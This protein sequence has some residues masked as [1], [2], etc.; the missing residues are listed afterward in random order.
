MK[1]AFLFMSI[2]FGA[3]LLKA[4][5]V[6]LDGV[7]WTWR[8]EGSKAQITRAY[9]E[10]TEVTIPESFTKDSV[11]YPVANIINLT[12]DGNTSIRTLTIPEGVKTLEV[13]ALWGC[14]ALTTLKLPTTIHYIGHSAFVECPN[15]TTIS[16]AKD[17]PH[18]KMD[19]QMTCV[20]SKDGFTLYT[21]LER[22]AKDDKFVIP[23]GVKTIES[24]AFSNNKTFKTVTIPNTV[25]EIKSGAFSQTALE[26]LELPGSVTTIGTSICDNC[27]NLKTVT[28]SD[29]IKRI[30]ANAFYG[31]RALESI[32]L[33][34]SVESV[35]QYAFADSRNLVVTFEGKPPAVHNYYS[36][37]MRSYNKDRT[38]GYYP[39]AYAKEWEAFFQANYSG[40]KEFYGLPMTEYD[41]EIP[42]RYFVYTQAVGDGV[43]GGAGWYTVGETVT[44]T[45]FP[46]TESTFCSYL[47]HPDV[48]IG[49][50]EHFTH[51]FAMPEHGVNV[52]AYFASKAAIETHCKAYQLTTKE[53]EKEALLKSGEYFTPDS[54]KTF[55]LETP[56]V[57]RVENGKVSVCVAISD[58]EEHNGQ[59]EWVEI[60]RAADEKTAFYKAVVTDGEEDAGEEAPE[61]PTEDET[62]EASQIAA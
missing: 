11:T 3:M 43:V 5:S 15:L 41:T 57:K 12:F 28:L 32:T 24:S 47:L 55:V 51:T 22:G 6:T 7:N 36:F 62:E 49:E 27:R 1:K 38:C 21:S 23:D 61:E 9:T 33:P 58:P 2:F 42:T 25:T 10:N 16:I 59:S 60:T 20:L 4:E 35:G 17:N 46:G 52:I 45:A 18:F 34:N 26:S 31:C 50:G 14:S 40:K 8:I 56:E 44:L 39:K 19:D 29:Q 53:A 54:L 37:G 48:Y 13:A 30:E